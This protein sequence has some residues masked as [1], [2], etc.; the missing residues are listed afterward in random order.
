MWNDETLDAWLADPKAFV[1]GNF[2]TFPGLEDTRARA[3]LIA[4]LKTAAAARE[5][6]LGQ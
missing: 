4:F 2:M 6:A 3:D 5:S 1:P